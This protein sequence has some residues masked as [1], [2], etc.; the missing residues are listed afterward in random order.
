MRTYV[1]G[2]IEDAELRGEFDNISEAAQRADPFIALIY[3]GV[4][5]TRPQ[6]G[7]YLAAA[8]VLGASRGLYRYDS[9]GG[10]Y[11]FIA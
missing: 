7:L 10:T 6:D 4:A 5:P 1:P 3:L 11:T 8:G 9:V 2:H